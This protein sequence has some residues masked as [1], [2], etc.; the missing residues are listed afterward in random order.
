MSNCE[1][2]WTR[3]GFV[4]ASYPPQFPYKCEKCG[5]TKNFRQG[6]EPM[7]D[8]KQDCKH[9]LL[10]EAI[11]NKEDIKIRVTPEQSKIVQE[12]CFALGVKWIHGS[13]VVDYIDCPFIFVSR[14]GD[15]FCLSVYDQEAYFEEI[16][17]KEYDFANKCW[18]NEERRLTMQKLTTKMLK[19]IKD[20]LYMNLEYQKKFLENH[21]HKEMAN[22]YMHQHIEDLKEVIKIL[23]GNNDSRSK[24]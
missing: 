22:H 23:E 20:S 24:D 8:A 5:I 16:R 7:L 10:V 13:T 9:P 18:V 11:K 4:L 14:W 2:K 19:L 17:D 3:T 21:K 1:H 6:E 12:I 15:V